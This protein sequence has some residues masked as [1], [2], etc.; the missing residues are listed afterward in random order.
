MAL[1]L[2]ARG[3]FDY[4]ELFA[5]PGSLR[6]FLPVWKGMKI[7]FIVHAA[8]LLTGMN[9]SARE[10]EG[11]NRK[12]IDE[13]FRF[14]DG[15]SAGY[16]I[17]HGGAGGTP[18]ESAR[19]FAGIRD[20][21]K[22]IEN[23]PF[24]GL[25]GERCVGFSPDQVRA[26]LGTGGGG[27]CLDMGHA[28]CAANALKREPMAFLREFFALRPVLYHLTDGDYSG[29]RDRHDHFGQGNFPLR[30]LAAL[31]PDAA[32]VSIEC[33]KD[34]QTNLDD[35]GLDAQRFKEFAGDGEGSRQ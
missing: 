31:I 23:K 21:R 35:F 13:A 9:L 33:K 7:P 18:E 32:M 22:V 5:Y 15:L 6:E 27:F 1:E 30:D 28:I 20:A 25:N 2:F 11:G 4:I 26:I 16:V 29:I 34:S 17:F 12:L 19:Q 14:A 24:T 3:A 8:H 10:A